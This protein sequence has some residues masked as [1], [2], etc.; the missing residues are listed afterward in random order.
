M[1]I[2]ASQKFN[3]IVK[4]VEFFPFEWSANLIAVCF[5]DS[6][7]IFKYIEAAQRKDVKKRLFK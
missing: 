3:Q 6:V 4:R 2:E 5:N 1:S 7:E